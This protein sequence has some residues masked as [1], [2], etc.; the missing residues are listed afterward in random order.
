MSSQSRLAFLGGWSAV[1]LLAGL[2][3][4]GSAGQPLGAQQ[5]PPARVQGPAVPAEMGRY[6]ISSFTTT[7]PGAYIL[8]TQTGEVFQ[9]IGQNAPVRV[10]QV[11]QPA[12]RK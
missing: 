5:P 9:V 12:P 7:S 2:L 3:L 11:P 8:D 1:V 6:Q 4:G 10:G